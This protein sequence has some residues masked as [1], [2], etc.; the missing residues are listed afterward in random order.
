[1]S[2]ITQIS[3]ASISSASVRSILLN[4]HRCLHYGEYR[5][6]MEFGCSALEGLLSLRIESVVRS[7]RQHL[8]AL[9]FG[10]RIVHTELGFRVE[11]SRMDY[12]AQDCVSLFQYAL[13]LHDA[14]IAR[15]AVDG[16]KAPMQS[17]IAER[18]LLALQALSRRCLVTRQPLRGRRVVLR[19]LLRLR[20]AL[21]RVLPSEQ[22]AAVLQARILAAILHEPESVAQTLLREFRFQCEYNFAKR[23]LHLHALPESQHYLNSFRWPQRREYIEYIAAQPGSRVLVTI[24][25]GDFLGAFRCIAALASPRRTAI[26]LRREQESEKE[27]G[28]VLANRLDHQILRHGQYNPVSIVSALRKGDHTLAILFD[29]RDEFGETIQA[30]FFGHQARFVK[31]PAQLAIMGKAPI[32]PFITFEQDGHSVIEMESIIDTRL[33]SDE[34]LQGATSRITQQLVSLAEKWISRTPSQWK[35]LTSIAGYFDVVPS[36]LG[37]NPA[38]DN[39]GVQPIPLFS[40]HRAESKGA[41]Q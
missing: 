25:M 15:V 5:R 17:S 8:P 35:Y 4:A 29:L 21:E 19:A 31:G 13:R 20:F 30:T 10:I 41:G 40:N 6:S 38:R 36:P 16:S 11:L 28:Y 18:T 27:K 2:S 12:G 37:T 33:L 26:S 14:L 34:S 22:S 9:D 32:L 7:I 3:L 39:D 1:M 23:H 24:H